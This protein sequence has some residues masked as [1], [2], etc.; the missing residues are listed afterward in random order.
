VKVLATSREPLRL[1]A[2]RVIVVPPLGLPD[3]NL[4]AQDFAASDSVR[5]FVARAQAAR[6]E[7][8]VTEANSPAVAAVC[9]RLDGLPLAIELAA[10]R[11]DHLAPAALLG[12]LERT[13]PLLTGGARDAP[14][15]QRTMRD[16]IAWSHDLLT[17]D[18]RILF[19][20]LSVFVG[21]CTLEAAEAVCGTGDR[22]VD[23]L[24]GIASLVSKSLVRY[25]EGAD[26]EPSTD[27]SR[28]RLLETVREFG[29]ER[30]IASD[31]E[32]AVRAAHVAWSP[33]WRGPSPWPSALNRVS[34]GRSNCVGWTGWRS[35]NR[36]CERP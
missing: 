15:R 28:Y 35:S 36:T 22:G 21:G 25:E 26:G 6:A 10:A 19:R 33:T 1:A 20:R 11:V 3:L 34:V 8:A 18:E 17:A 23:V 32:P 2:E 16:A 29:L 9:R 12:R 7:F 27:S 31:E 5:L 14:D 24:A 30:L 13:L 4:P